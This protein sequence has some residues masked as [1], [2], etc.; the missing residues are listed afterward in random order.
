MGVVPVTNIGN[1]WHE[2]NIDST[3]VTTHYVK[4]EEDAL[5]LVANKRADITIE[6]VHT[7]SYLIN[8]YNLSDKVVPSKAGFG[9]L[10]M[11]LL[12][13]QKSP[14]KHLFP[15]INRVIKRLSDNGTLEQI[16]IQYSQ[17]QPTKKKKK[18]YD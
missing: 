14:H 13:S 10:N 12:F 11:Y 16:S 7:G 1:S 18:K 2:K 17:I 6:P 4:N 3:G 9:P 5:K 8:K 15:E